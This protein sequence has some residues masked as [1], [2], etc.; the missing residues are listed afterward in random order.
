PSA[1]TLEAFAVPTGPGVR[2]DTAAYAGYRPNPRFDS[3]LAKVVVHVASPGLPGVVA[4]AARALGELRVDGVATNAPFLRHLLRPPPAPGV[5]DVRGDEAVRRRARHGARGG[6]PR[7]PS[8]ACHARRSA[9]GSPRSARRAGARE[10][11]SAARDARGR[12]GRRRR[13]AHAGH[14]RRG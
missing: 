14:G 6:V 7:A 11:A 2:V 8:V 10:D 9:G 3:L 4:K 12:R 1:G 13:R 5:G